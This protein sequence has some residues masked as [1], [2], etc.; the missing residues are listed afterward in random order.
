M[1]DMN[2]VEN[3]PKELFV[4]TNTVYFVQKFNL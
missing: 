1:V 2:A 4:I 3:Y